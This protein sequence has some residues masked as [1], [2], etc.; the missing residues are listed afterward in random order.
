MEKQ[1]KIGITLSGGGVRGAAHAAVL[2]VL[3]D[4]GIEPDMISGSS[5]GAMA[6]ALYA[7]GYKPTEILDFFDENS[8]IFRWRNFSRYKPGILDAE[9]YAEIFE[10]WLNGH[11]FESLHKE[12]HICVTDVLN[13]RMRFFSSGE[14]VLPVLASAALPGVFSPVEIGEDWYIDGGVMNNFPTEPLLGRCSFLIGSFVS[15][16]KR[17]EKEELNSTIKLLN[18]ASGLTFLSSSMYKFGQCDFLFM[19]QELSNYGT[20]DS[21]KIREIYEVGY[22]YASKRVP[23]LLLIM[24]KRRQEA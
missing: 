8:N 10:P 22:E 6:G 15:P 7:A 23:E 19:P 4:N 5:A 17:V 2:A 24:E 13:A 1:K 16:K 21:K 14:L 12:L 9:K 11:T 3:E 20:F 18:R